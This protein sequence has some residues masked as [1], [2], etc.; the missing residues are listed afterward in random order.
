MNIIHADFLL[1]IP[2]ISF[3]V[4]QLLRISCLFIF[5]TILCQNL[6]FPPSPCIYFGAVVTTNIKSGTKI[7]YSN[8]HFITEVKQ[9]WVT[10]G[11]SMGD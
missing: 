9:Q 5:E 7:Q 2:I 4:F 6:F 3:S 11:I 1:I 10:F 8:V